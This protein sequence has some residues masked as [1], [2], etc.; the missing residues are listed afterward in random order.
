MRR[1]HTAGSDVSEPKSESAHSIIGLRL[2]CPLKPLICLCSLSGLSAGL[3][4]QR[5]KVRLL[6]QVP[7]AH[8]RRVL[9]DSQRD[10]PNDGC[11]RLR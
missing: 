2:S 9:D 6:S 3:K 4:R 7:V 5:I 10:V 8:R 1:R 11:K